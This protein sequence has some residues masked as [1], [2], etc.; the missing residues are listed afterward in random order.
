MLDNIFL[1]DEDIKIKID[2][3]ENKVRT[4]V[5]MKLNGSKS[6]LIKSKFKNKQFEF[7]IKLS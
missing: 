7:N 3:F 2:N 1:P 5:P 4:Q 6:F